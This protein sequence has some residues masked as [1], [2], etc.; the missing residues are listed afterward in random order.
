MT[1]NRQILDPI[2]K[3][4]LVLQPEELVRQLWVQYLIQELG[5]PAQLMALEQKITCNGLTRRYDVVMYNRAM[6]PSILIECKAPKIGL[7]QATFDQAAQYNMVLKV[8]YLVVSNGRS[9]YACQVDWDKEDYVFI[10]R[11]PH[12]EQLER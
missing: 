2:R 6:E 11:I 4:Y 9:T 3:K 8:P 5:C 12:F 10:D 7:S 1:E